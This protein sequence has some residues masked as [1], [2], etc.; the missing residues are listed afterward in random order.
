MSKKHKN[1]QQDLSVNVSQRTIRRRIAT[2]LENMFKQ[3][4]D[5]NLVSNSNINCTTDESVMNKV[6]Q[7][8]NNNQN[9]D[10]S[11]VDN[12]Y[13]NESISNLNDFN[14]HDLNQSNQSSSTENFGMIVI[15]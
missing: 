3:I 2:E 14:T 4:S 15:S 11:I 10:I 12:L 6:L 5:Q 1:N 9:K 13:L 7:G 8:S